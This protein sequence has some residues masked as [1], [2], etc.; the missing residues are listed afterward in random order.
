VH[1]RGIAF[2]V[3]AAAPALLVLAVIAAI[4]VLIAGLAWRGGLGAP[5]PAGL[6]V[7][8][9][10]ANVADR[11][12]GGSVVDFLDVGRWPTFNLA[13]V[14]LVAGIAMLLVTA[15]RGTPSTGRNV[16]RETTQETP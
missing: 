6:V 12:S 16:V 1:N 13:D 9:A 5:V 14:F 4:A 2:G 11:A 15:G 7:G 8:G 3:A 10:L